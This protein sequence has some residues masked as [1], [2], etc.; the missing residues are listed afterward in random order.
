[1]QISV[2]KNMDQEIWVTTNLFSF[3]VEQEIIFV[4]PHPV[5]AW[6]EMVIG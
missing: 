1:M 4:I 2:L 6:D 3:G 5:V